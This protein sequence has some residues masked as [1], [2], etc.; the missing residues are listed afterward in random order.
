VAVF[1]VLEE[2]QEQDDGVIK[3]LTASFPLQFQNDL[4]FFTFFDLCYCLVYVL[5][6]KY[7]LLN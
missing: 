5:F 7:Y 3:G 2:H 4:F 1:R 6:I